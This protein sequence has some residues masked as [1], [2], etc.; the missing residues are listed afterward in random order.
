MADIVVGQTIKLTEGV[1]RITAPNAGAM[2]GPGTNSY[3]LGKKRLTLVDPGPLDDSHINVLLDATKGRLE[4]ILVTHT[5]P[6]HSPA[7]AP[8]AK[9]TGVPCV[10]LLASDSLHQDET[11]V[12]DIELH[13]EKQIMVEDQV[14]T[15]VHTPGHVNNH[16]CF[17]H[18]NGMLFTGDHIMEGSTVVIVPPGG[19]MSQ[20]MASLKLLKSY[21]IKQ[22]VPGHGHVMEQPEAVV[23][24][25]LD[26]RTMREN[27][28]IAKLKQHSGCTVEGLLPL[29]YDDVD[30]AM[31]HMAALS[32]LAHL[33]KLAEEGKSYCR[34][35]QWYWH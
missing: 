2:T 10:G 8:I 27:K 30:T 11:F 9:V 17:L 18:E 14:L 22:L 23:D 25:L 3:I 7:A 21:P 1:C 12:P 28:V 15:A 4:Q 33:I 16:F 32:M 34:D 13:H 31:H 35:D 19:N 26:H 5:H 24:W 29:V 6:D 20:Y